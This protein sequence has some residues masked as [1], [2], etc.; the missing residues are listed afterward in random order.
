MAPRIAPTTP[1]ERDPET[2]ALVEAVGGLNIFATLAHHPKALKR[3]LVFGG[4]VLAKSTLT[5]R[6]RE[7]L[8]LRVGWRCGSVYEFGQHTVI[9]ARAGI[10]ADEVR[11]IAAEGTEGWSAEDAALL[12]AVDELVADHRIGDATWAELAGRFD[13]Q[14]LIDLLFTVGQ[15]VLVSMTLNSL[16]VEREP[17]VPGWPA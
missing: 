16:G 5:E 13:E 6:D 12:R 2:A 9:G 3:W 11:R 15:Y 1:E 10:T 8:I 4:H 7:L 14:E 17:G